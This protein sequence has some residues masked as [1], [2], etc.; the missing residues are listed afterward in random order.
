MDAMYAAIEAKRLREEKVKYIK[1]VEKNWAER[2]LELMNI[3]QPHILRG[4]VELEVIKTYKRN[5]PKTTH[6]HTPL[7][8]RQ[9]IEAFRSCPEMER[10]NKDRRRE[11]KQLKMKRRR[12]EKKWREMSEK[13]MAALTTEHMAASSP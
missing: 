2:K 3:S 13:I 6:D 8:T 7:T 5:H 10:L 12:L 1:K 4:G 9:R 11:V